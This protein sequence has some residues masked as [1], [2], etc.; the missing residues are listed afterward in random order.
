MG[1]RALERLLLC[2]G[3]LVQ[4]FQDAERVLYC[5]SVKVVVEV[6]VRGFDRA[7]D[8]FH[9]GNPLCQFLLSVVIIVPRSLAAAVPP[10]VGKVSC[11]MHLRR[12]KWLVYNCV[13]DVVFGKNLPSLVSE[14]GFVPEFYSVLEAV[15]QE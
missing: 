15:R 10:Y 5:I 7:F 8:L 4:H 13:G 14:P 3:E 1:S 12:E 11:H 2:W 6:S 9:L